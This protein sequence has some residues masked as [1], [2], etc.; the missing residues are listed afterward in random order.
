M[1]PLL[2]MAQIQPTE[3]GHKPAETGG[4]IFAKHGVHAYREGSQESGWAQEGRVA[5]LRDPVCAT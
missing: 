5:Q 1:P 3:A 4:A 2:G